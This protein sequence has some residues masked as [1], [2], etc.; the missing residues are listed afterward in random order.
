[1]AQQA[2]LAVPDHQ[3]AEKLADEL[4]SPLIDVVPTRR[5]LHAQS[6]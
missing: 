1:M 5:L 4:I 6:R 3:S 2:T